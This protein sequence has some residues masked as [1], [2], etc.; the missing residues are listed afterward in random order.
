MAATTEATSANVGLALLGGVLATIATWRGSGGATSEGVAG[1]SAGAEG[2]AAA[3]AGRSEHE[4]V[5]S[6][7]NGVSF[8]GVGMVT[9]LPG[10][11]RS[12]GAPPTGLLSPVEDWKVRTPT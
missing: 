9:P 8:F 5:R 3:K 10:G 1:R 11:G 12:D 6:V 4:V 7:T 2:S